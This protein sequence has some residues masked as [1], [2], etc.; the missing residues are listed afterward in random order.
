MEPVTTTD[1]TPNP[2]WVPQACTLPTAQQPLRVA[3]F[4]TLFT[5]ALRAVHRL[6]P[7]RLR[8]LLDGATT[9][10]ATARD[11]TRRESECCSFFTFAVTRHDDDQTVGLE[12]AVPDGHTA[13]LDG[14]AERASAALG[15]GGNTEQP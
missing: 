5:T 8:L 11:L 14:L 10:E 9:V 4:D 12:V 2:A 3:E 1:S 6:D 15:T 7:N 13:V